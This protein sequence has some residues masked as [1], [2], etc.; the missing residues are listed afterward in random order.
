[1]DDSSGE[2]ARQPEEALQFAQFAMDNASVE[3]F[4]FGSDARIHY[5]NNQACKMLGY[6]KEE[7]LKLSL[8]D[9]DP[10]FTKDQWNM[11]WESLKVDLTQT[12]DTQHRRKNGEIFPVEI[13]ANF[14]KLD[15]L[16]YNV[17]YAK[18]ITEQINREDALKNSER[19]SREFISNLQVGVIIQSANAEIISNNQLALDLLGL[20]EE[21][22]LILTGTSFTK[23]APHFP[24]TLIPFRMPLRHE[25]LSIMW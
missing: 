3:I 18:D 2:I 14:V 11:H 7:L 23:M 8:T 13:I 6:S 17:A 10:L 12:F 15:N 22:H 25:N 9:L 16:E 1:M 4:W 20:T 21:H 24:D 19:R 5:V